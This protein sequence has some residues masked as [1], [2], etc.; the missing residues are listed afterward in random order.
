M[1][2][3]HEGKCTIM[4]TSQWI[5]LRMRIVSDK[6]C[7]ENQNIYAMFN[8]F[9]FF[10]KS[11]HFWDNGEKYFIAGQA[12]DKNKKQCMCIACWITNATNPHSEYVLLMALP[13]QQWLCKQASM[14]CYTYI[15][16]LLYLIISIT[17]PTLLKYRGFS[18]DHVPKGANR[19]SF[20]WYFSTF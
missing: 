4:I 12:T 8:N 18:Y 20:H 6:R 10:Q 15:A 3:L 2:I 9:L 14:V 16:C 11:C 7:I 17:L 19:I 13:W 1:C 5:L